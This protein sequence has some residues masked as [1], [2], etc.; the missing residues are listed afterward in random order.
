[1]IRSFIIFVGILCRLENY[2]FDSK[3]KCICT[4]THVL[5]LCSFRAISCVIQWC[6]N[7]E[8][9][10]SV[11]Q[12]WWGWVCLCN[13]LSK[14]VRFSS[15]AL[16]TQAERPSTPYPLPLSQHFILAPS[17]LHRRPHH[18]HWSITQLS[19]NPVTLPVTSPLQPYPWG[20]LAICT[21]WP[22]PDW[23]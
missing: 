4:L 15:L 10:V 5:P 16:S 18:I 6:W 2:N 1:M 21:Q 11:V 19:S 14:S 3:G 8:R 20:W 7:E 17:S 23:A 22:L 9:E 13:M 12:V